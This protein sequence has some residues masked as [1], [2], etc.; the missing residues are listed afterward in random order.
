MTTAAYKIIPDT[1][2]INAIERDLRFYPSTVTEPRVLSRQRLC[3]TCYERVWFSVSMPQDA[4]CLCER[5][6]DDAIAERVDA[7]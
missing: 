2:D 7:A 4:D 5:C 6:Y 1:S 3:C